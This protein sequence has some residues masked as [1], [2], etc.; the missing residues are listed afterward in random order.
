MRNSK[1]MTIRPQLNTYA[2][3]SISCAA[4]WTVILAVGQRRLDPDTRNMLRLSCIGW[5]SGWTSASIARAGYP[6]P[7]KLTPKAQQRLELVSLGL[8]ALGFTSV[9][10]LL[11]NGARG[12]RYATSTSRCSGC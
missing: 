10:R 2:G 1:T 5:W 8:V 11:A 9:I 6:P 4:V 3:Y 12:G 7:K